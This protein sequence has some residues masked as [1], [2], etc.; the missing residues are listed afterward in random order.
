MKRAERHIFLF[1]AIIRQSNKSNFPLDILYQSNI[2]WG[3]SSTQSFLR[4]LW[5]I[6]IL[7]RLC[8]AM[9]ARYECIGV[10]VPLTAR[11]PSRPRPGPGPER[12][13][14]NNWSYLLILGDIWLP[15]F[16]PFA[17]IRYRLRMCSYRR[18]FSIILCDTYDLEWAGLN[19]EPCW[20]E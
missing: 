6:W 5:R 3:F 13:Q 17:C 11:E 4:A 12:N 1:E 10:Y 19:I 2:V 9:S 16:A 7:W 8:T 18:V 15:R 20:G 14:C